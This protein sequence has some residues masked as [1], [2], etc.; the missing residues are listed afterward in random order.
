VK[1]A[2]EKRAVDAESQLDTV[3]DKLV[4][5][6]LEKQEAETVLAKAKDETKQANAKLQES[7]KTAKEAAE[8]SS[9]D[10][11]ALTK[12][13]AGSQA[14]TKQANAKLQE[15]Q[16]TAKEA[17]EKSSEDVNALTKQL[18]GSQA[19]TKQANAKLQESQKT[20]KA[21]AEKSIIIKETAAKEQTRLKGQLSK[22]QAE[23]T[24]IKKEF[25]VLKT[26]TTRLAQSL[27]KSEEQAADLQAKLKQ[28]EINARAIEKSRADAAAKLQ[29]LQAAVCTEIAQVESK[30]K[31]AYDTMEAAM[32]E[33]TASCVPEAPAT[34][35]NGGVSYKVTSSTGI[36]T[37]ASEKDAVSYVPNNAAEEQAIQISRSPDAWVDLIVK[38]QAQVDQFAYNV[39]ETCSAA[40]QKFMELA[41]VYMSASVGMITGD[42]KDTAIN[43]IGRDQTAYIGRGK[44]LIGITGKDQVIE[45]DPT[46]E[47]D[48]SSLAS[49]VGC[50]AA[51]K[52]Q[53]P[54][55]DASDAAKAEV[56]TD[57]DGK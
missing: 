16:K 28:T 52:Q 15:S 11:N 10:V 50:G 39:R 3:N 22:S 42:H 45:L 44:E 35:V 31:Q 51:K 27:K 14:E 29:G 36:G 32:K 6:G 18:A 8:K 21:A 33:M 9:D 56:D 25:G 57:T 2:L 5:C 43:V 54:W 20:A 40:T 49:I 47:I 34:K 55:D 26:R 41:R 46:N 38:D 37:K 7:Q 13:L 30:A 17:A 24:Q 48:L 53:F 23:A 12:Q 1:V 19:E 4:T